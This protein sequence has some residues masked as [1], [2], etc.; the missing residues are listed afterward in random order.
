[1]QLQRMA[2]DMRREHDVGQRRQ[3]VGRMRL[4]CVHVKARAGDGLV[5][6]RRDQSRLVDD[7]AAR[8]VDD[9]A[10]LAEFLQDIGIDGVIGI[11]PARTAIIRTLHHSAS[12]SSVGKY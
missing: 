5:G 12:A 9:V 6:Q 7:R 2:A 3:R 10:V 4:L 11:R 8:N 1:M